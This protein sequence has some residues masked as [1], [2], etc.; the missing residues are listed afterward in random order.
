MTWRSSRPWPTPSAPHIRSSCSSGLSQTLPRRR[1]KS[2]IGSLGSPLPA[3]FP[4]P[5]F[6]AC[7]SRPTASRRSPPRPSRWR[8]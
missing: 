2:P 6:G 7:L 1:R 8:A 5:P 4:W 3:R